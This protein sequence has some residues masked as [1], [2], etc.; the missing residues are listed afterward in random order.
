M[1]RCPRHTTCEACG[2]AGAILRCAVSSCVNHAGRAVG[3]ERYARLPPPPSPDDEHVATAVPLGTLALRGN[4]WLCTPRRSVSRD[5]VGVDGSRDG[6]G[7][8]GSRDG[9]IAGDGD[10]A[11]CTDSR[12]QGCPGQRPLDLR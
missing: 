9:V 7:V 3:A 5:G 1:S 4:Q 10:I 8:D 6:V 2:E 12:A 11:P